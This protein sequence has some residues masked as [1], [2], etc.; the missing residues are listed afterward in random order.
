MALKAPK[1]QLFEAVIK[2]EDGSS[3]EVTFR[4]PRTTDVYISEDGNSNLQ[5]LYTLANM[6]K[7][8][9][10][11]VQVETEDGSICNVRTMK[12]LISI[13]VVIDLSDVVEK[14]MDAKSKAEE[15]KHR[16]LKKSESG[17]GSGKKA[18]PQISD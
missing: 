16:L 18:T 5:T 13:G 9:K 10:T 12:E 17:G 11:P 2:F 14:W 8:L 7:P 6:A 4:L 1:E 3:Q 15:E